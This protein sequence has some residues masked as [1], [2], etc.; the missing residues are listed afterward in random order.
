MD[1]WLTLGVSVRAGDLSCNLNPFQIKNSLGSSSII[2]SIS[3][4][5]F[6]FQ[7]RGIDDQRRD[8]RSHY[9][10]AQEFLGFFI[11]D[12]SSELQERQLYDLNYLLAVAGDYNQEFLQHY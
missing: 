4:N 11:Y 7:E 10:G 9:L 2:N 5:L 12:S 6:T 1:Y 8:E 3:F